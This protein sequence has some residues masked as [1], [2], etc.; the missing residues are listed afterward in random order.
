MS[1]AIAN[2]YASALAEVLSGDNADTTPEAALSQLRDFSASLEAAPELRTLFGAPAVDV[3]SKK[4]LAAAIGERI[5]FSQSV[6][7]LVF[8]LL[9]NRR[10]GL[11]P[12][13]IGAFE[14]W[15]D[16]SQGISRISVTSAAPL[17][18]DQREA[19]IEKFRRMTGRQ[20]HASFDLDET[21]LGG[22]VVRVGS[23]LYD[24]SL[25]SQLKMLDR[26]MSGRL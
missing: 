24:G 16:E 23:K 3:E 1:L 21:L 6:R 26:A 9:D 12:E 18:D 11:L 15:L 10:I 4:R 20:I 8:V 22:A 5:G 25:S 13:L 2:R 14:R 7:N 19:I 17:L